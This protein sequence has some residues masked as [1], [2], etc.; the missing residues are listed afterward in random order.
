[1]LVS[2]EK[3]LK[4]LEM[5]GMNMLSKAQQIRLVYYYRNAVLLENHQDL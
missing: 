1:M 3:M 4:N 5:T 2:R